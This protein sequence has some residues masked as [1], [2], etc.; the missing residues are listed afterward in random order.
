VAG[1]VPA[2][3]RLLWCG[4]VNL[5]RL[6]A[7][8][9][10]LLFAPIPRAQPQPAAVDWSHAQPISVLMVENSFIPERL[11]FRHGRAY[12]LHLE[13]RGKELHE[14]T[15]PAFLAAAIVRNPAMLSNGG[16]EIVLQPGTS[17]D[18]DLVPMKPGTYNL[19]CADHDWDGMTGEIT[20]E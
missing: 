12:Q 3:R 1:L 18:V 9:A 4:R 20:V 11:T 5:P 7:A 6:V 19:T 17:I 15:A 2:I 8:S 13:N 14:F 10:L 16:Q